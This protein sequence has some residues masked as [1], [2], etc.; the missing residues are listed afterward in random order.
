VSTRSIFPAP[1][2]LS[3]YAQRT[4]RGLSQR[5]ALDVLAFAEG[6]F[7][8]QRYPRGGLPL[9]LGSRRAAWA[10]TKAVSQFITRY[11]AELAAA[12]LNLCP[13]HESAQAP[14]AQAPGDHLP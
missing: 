8:L 5:L 11:E 12:S 10:T 14:A 2:G 7:G 9:R 6:N 3:V 13:I 4:L 1:T